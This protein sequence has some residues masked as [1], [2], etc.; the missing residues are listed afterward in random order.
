VYESGQFHLG[1]NDER[2]SHER[3]DMYKI[4]FTASLDVRLYVLHGQC[5][6]F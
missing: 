3:Y 2:T 6:L 1:W 5:L 4:V